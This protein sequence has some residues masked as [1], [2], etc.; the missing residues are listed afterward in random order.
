[1][2]SIFAETISKS[3]CDYRQMLRRHL[4][5]AERA[6]KL[7]ELN[8]K[9]PNHNDEMALYRTAQMIIH[10][11]ECN[12][13]MMS[14]KNYYS[15]SG[16]GK[17]CQY[18]KEFLSNYVIENDSVTHRAQKASRALIQSIQLLALPSGKMTPEIIEKINECNVTIAH[19]GS[20]EQCDLYKE[21]LQR[22][23]HER[24]SLFDSLS[25]QFEEYLHQRHNVSEAA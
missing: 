6:T 13:D 7:A 22:Y 1:M 19:Y 12:S 17:F 23:R 4:N 5:Q 15:Y 8:L 16:V 11:I 18:L 10:D 14:K 3:I 20:D 21:N 25:R 9:D 24:G 2:S